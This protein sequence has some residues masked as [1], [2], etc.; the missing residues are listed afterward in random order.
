MSKED[1]QKQLDILIPEIE[2]QNWI[3]NAQKKLGINK[4]RPRNTSDEEL[5]DYL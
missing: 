3:L 5:L 4:R 1:K 2:I